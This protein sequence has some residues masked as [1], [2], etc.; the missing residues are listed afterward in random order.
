[1]S[2]FIVGADRLGNIANNL[3]ESGCHSITHLKGRK[4][5]CMRKLQIPAGTDL[6]LVMTDYIDHNIAHDIRSKAKRQSIPVLFS[7]R[8]W[9]YLF[10][11]LKEFIYSS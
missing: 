1:L 7:K 5:I 6:I 9:T 4:N 10:P 8:S 2:I 3:K 11:K